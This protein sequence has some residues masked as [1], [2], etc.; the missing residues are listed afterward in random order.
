MSQRTCLRCSEAFSPKRVDS[1][2]CSRKCS[3][4]HWLDSPTKTCDEQDCE[5]PLRAKG[6]CALHYKRANAHKRK[7][8]HCTCAT[9]AS[10]FQSPTRASRFCSY[11]CRDLA[12]YGDTRP[13]YFPNCLNC[14]DVF[15]SRDAN[16]FTCS[17]ECRQELDVKTRPV[18]P[19]KV[20]WR[21]ERE[22]PGCGCHFSPLYTPNML[23]CSRRCSRRVSRWRRRASE[24]NAIGSW[25]WSD[26]MRVA[27]RFGFCCAYCG[28]KPDGQL[29]PD[30]VVPLSRGGYNSTANLLPACR[31]C[32]ADKRDLLLSE[33]NAD[34][35]RRGLSPR[36]TSWAPEDRR[37]RHLTQA[38]LVAA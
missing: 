25:V 31:P 20:E 38:L 35:E 32:N 21:T 19:V 36:L 10:E 13:V 5:R 37:F 15:T 8:Y 1:Q 17:S 14:G 29:D 12:T 6:M 2:F 3:S 28:E 18:V 23:T 30:H 4:R 9:C 11:S 26:F 16:R 34:R 33:W 27:H 24:V 22:C 7:Q